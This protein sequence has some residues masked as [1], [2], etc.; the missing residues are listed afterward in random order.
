MGPVHHVIRNTLTPHPDNAR[1][2]RRFRSVASTEFRAAGDGLTMAGPGPARPERDEP[3]S[4]T[5]AA[6]RNI[7][8][9]RTELQ[10]SGRTSGGAHHEYA[11]RAG[12]RGDRAMP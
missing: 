5:I 8:Q 7:G 4:P 1:L 2:Q 10:S 9:L 3:S 12:A 6:D 11:N